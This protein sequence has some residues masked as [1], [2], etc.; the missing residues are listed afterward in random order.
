MRS[1]LHTMNTKHAHYQVK[2]LAKNM[3]YRCQESKSWTSL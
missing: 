3:R 2:T 1:W